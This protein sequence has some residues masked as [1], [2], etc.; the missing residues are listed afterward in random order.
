M[1]NGR[2]ACGRN[3]AHCEPRCADPPTQ[4]AR[5]LP[6]FGG[7]AARRRGRNVT[8]AGRHAGV[9]S[10]RVAQHPKTARPAPGRAALHRR[11]P[12]CTAQCREDSSR[13]RSGETCVGPKAR[14]GWRRRLAT[15]TWEPQVSP[16]GPWRFTCIGPRSPARNSAELGAGT[17]QSIQQIRNGQERGRGFHSRLEDRTPPDAA[18]SPRKRDADADLS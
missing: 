17:T 4:S 6:A 18:A 5:A 11:R 13:C 3:A 16:G 9:G 14:R 12:R 7:M 10:P 8:S 15:T 1:A 2:R